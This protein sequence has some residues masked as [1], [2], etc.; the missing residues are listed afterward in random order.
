MYVISVGVSSVVC[1]I[2]SLE[3]ASAEEFMSHFYCAMLGT[4]SETD[5]TATPTSTSTT[6]MD[7]AEAVRSA[8]LNFMHIGDNLQHPNRWAGYMCRG[9]GVDMN[10]P[11]V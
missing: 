1:A 3:D 11:I 6:P 7:C 4:P 9:L 8:T 2:C 10:G 5:T